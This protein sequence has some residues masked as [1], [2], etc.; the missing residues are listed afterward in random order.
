MTLVRNLMVAG[1]I[2]SLTACGSSPPT[3]EEVTAS[4]KKIMPV[5]FEV[6]QVTPVKEITGLSEIVA[7]VDKQPVV[8]YTDKTGKYVLSGS[9][10]AVESKKNLTLETQMKFKGTEHKSVEALPAPAAAPAK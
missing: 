3:K 7:L 4:I 6:V 10:V 8:F 2:I 9:L 1:F 5:N